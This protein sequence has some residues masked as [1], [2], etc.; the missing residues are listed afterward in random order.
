[1]GVFVGTNFVAGYGIYAFTDLSGITAATVVLVG[2]ANALVYCA[3]KSYDHFYGFGRSSEQENEIC[4]QL[5]QIGDDLEKVLVS[6][7]ESN[8]RSKEA[9]RTIEDIEEANEDERL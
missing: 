1:M 4:D 5:K 8:A 6:L 9:H 2:L 3:K 7:E